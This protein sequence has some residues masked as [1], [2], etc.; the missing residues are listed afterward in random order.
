MSPRFR[1]GI[2]L[3]TTNCA[4]A[5]VAAGDP[6]GRSVVLEIPQ[7]ETD[8]SATTSTTL[9]SCLYRPPGTPGAGPW[10]AGRWA[11]ARAAEVPGRVVRSAKSWLTHHAADRRAA[12]LPLGSTELG[13]AEQLSPVRAQTLLLRALADAWDAAHPDAPLA[14]QDVAVTVPASFDPVAQQLTLEAAAA[15]GFPSGTLL[16]EEPQAAFYA[17]RETVA[18]A[19][20]REG[21]AGSDP[22]SKR[23]GHV[24]VV[25]LGGGTTDFSLFSVE[26]RPG[27]APPHLR[28]IA[29]S[30]HILLGGDNLDLAL[31]HH[32]ESRLP[33]GTELP[34]TAFAQLLARCREIKEEAL[35][36]T[37]APDASEPERHWP[38]AISRPGAS[39]IAGTIRL[40][41]GAHEVE[42]LLIDGFFPEVGATERPLRSAAGLREMGLPYARDPA[43]TRHLAD[44]LRDRPPVDFLLCNGGL[45]KAPAVRE[46]LLAHLTHWQNGHSP[47]LLQNTDPDLAVA[48][49]AARFL[50]L[51][52]LGDATRIEAGASHAYY[53][54]V[55]ESSLLCVLPGGTPPEHAIE[56]GVPGLRALIGKP[57]S[58]PLFRSSR[59]P[60]DTAGQVVPR[61]GE[62][63]HELPAIETVLTPPRGKPQPKD[64]LVPVRLRTTLRATGLLRVDL[65]CADDD[66]GWTTPWPLEF[67]L[68][69]R[70]APP[71]DP[72]RSVPS[73]AAPAPP[74]A[75][76]AILPLAIPAAAAMSKRFR[77]GTTGKDRLT[78]N[79]VFTAA[80]KVLAAPRTAWNAP[81][82]RALWPSW[83]ELG[84]RRS[85][86]AE[87]EETWLQVAGFL[88]RPGRGVPGDEDRVAALWPLLAAPPQGTR[89][90]VR[91]QRWICL[92][93]IAA[94]LTP[95]QVAIVGDQVAA[96]W[97]AGAAPT[98][99]LA[100]LVGAL[101]TLPGDRRT[102]LATRLASSLQ[103]RPEDGAAWKGL[104]RL[105]SRVLFHAGTD[106]V[107]PPE[108]VVACWEQLKDVSVPEA[109]RA[110][111]TLAWL[112]AGRRTGLRGLDVP[113]SCRQGIDRLLRGWG[114]PETR[115]L[116]LHELV[117]VVATEQSALIGESLPGGL[118]LTLD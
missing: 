29:V 103:V 95:E 76:A 61:H 19:E 110:D 81:L 67:S 32:V 52:A 74:S 66:L 42:R 91:V 65:L 33:R 82:V 80:E 108:V 4:L 89:P 22:V 87:H 18:R 98:A 51:R 107:I 15:A 40:D 83:L 2:D 49:G 41:V 112:R 111:A 58:F 43:I 55:G 5:S 115:R 10:I 75:T 94:G 70:P 73:A 48:R 99:E 68:R 39:L 54:G 101:E 9:P 64:P 57:A 37:A 102:A 118:S 104:G 23:P 53:V 27:G 35:G 28:R 17:W 30:D 92:R 106:Q 14:S 50:H 96:E 36:R 59:R 11:R 44:F 79:A 24:L 34:P 46:R 85:A 77:L 21:A 20:S 117:P 56:A 86:S 71:P 45:T 7:P 13:P 38:I 97:A 25:D 69:S 93:R 84:G 8:H 109:V 116:P 12:F 60:D 63:F 88:L 3:G 62:E 1:I 16:L 31:A 90:A 114:V 6:E 78:A 113:S 47:L 26:P 100:L 72:A 105:L